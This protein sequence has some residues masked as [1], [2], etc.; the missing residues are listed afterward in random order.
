MDTRW[1]NDWHQFVKGELDEEPPGPVTT[2]E[3]LDEK[4]NPLPNLRPKIDYRGVSPMAYA[5]F[6]ELYGKDRSPELLRY[7]VD[8]YQR[9][10]PL[11]RQVNIKK[12]CVVRSLILYLQPKHR[13]H[14]IYLVGQS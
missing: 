7:K 8:I 5:C 10:I 13:S 14:R 4:N 9:E 1:L 3:L 12:P 11:D 2:K 6:V